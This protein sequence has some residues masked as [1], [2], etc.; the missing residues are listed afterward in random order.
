MPEIFPVIDLTPWFEGGGD[1]RAEVAKQVDEALR[2]S[3]ILLVTGHRVPS[4]LRDRTR[5]V[6]RE[7]FRLPADVKGRS[8]IAFGGRGW[9]APRFAE[10]EGY[11]GT[12]SMAPDLKESFSFGADRVTGDDA[13]DARWFRPNTWPAEVPG[14]R[15]VVTEYIERM[16]A[17]SDELM[18]LCAVALGL[19]ADFFASYL[20]HPTYGFNFNRYPP[21][22]PTRPPAPGQFNVAPHTDFGTITVLDREPGPGGLQVYTSEDTWVDAPYV[23]EAL[24]VNIGD[25]LARWTGDRWHATR[26]RVLP[27]QASAPQDDLISLV[28]FFETN[29][30]ALIESME[31][32]IGRTSFPSVLSHEYLRSRL[33]SIAPKAKH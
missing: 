22:D 21:V 9:I 4:E 8:S 33:A 26:H 5:A 14:M 18:S 3:G 12:A 2:T 23:P 6:A 27:P 15:P 25:L 30:N 11:E 20:D 10:A 1:E 29:H 7:F 24:T 31:P 17:L 16:H 19:G 28:Y 32:S 13:V